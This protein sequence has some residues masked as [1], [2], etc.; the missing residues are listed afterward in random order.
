MFATFSNPPL[1]YFPDSQVG[2]DLAL[3]SCYT[4]HVAGREIQ[5]PLRYYTPNNGG[6]VVYALQKSQYLCIHTHTHTLKHAHAYT[7][8]NGPHSINIVQYILYL[9]ILAKSQLQ[10]SE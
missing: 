3:A 2:L 8:M 9:I 1:Q 10:H 4:M 6:N 7:E 5:W